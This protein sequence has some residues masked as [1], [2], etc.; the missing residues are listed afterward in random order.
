VKPRGVICPSFALNG[1][2]GTSNPTAGTEN[3]SPVSGAGVEAGTGIA[4]AGGVGAGGE[5]GM[6]TGSCSTVFPSMVWAA[7]ALFSDG[8]DELWNEAIPAIPATV[9]NAADAAP[10]N[11]TGMVGR[12]PH[13]PFG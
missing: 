12:W 6:T 1:L 11:T 2:S 9:S 13:H 10:S 4:V 5:D 3:R 8:A 7:D